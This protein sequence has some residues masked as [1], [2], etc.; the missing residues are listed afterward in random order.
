MSVHSPAAV[1][2]IGLNAR[3]PHAIDASEFFENLL[4]GRDCIAPMPEDRMRDCF[5]DRARIDAAHAQRLSAGYI[6]FA[7]RF[8]NE[9]F[10]FLP[11][12]AA[13]M[14]PQQ[15]LFMQTAWAALEDAGYGPQSLKGRR[16]GVFVG[17]GNADYPVMMR[18]DGVPVDAYRA[19]GM[20]ITCIANRVSYAFD[21]RGPSHSI[22]TACSSSLIAI[23]QACR[24]IRDGV[25]K[26][27]IA[28]GVNLLLG[29]ELFDAFTQAGMLSP[30][31]RC[32]VFDAA[33]DGYVRGEGVVAMVLRS[34]QDAELHRDYIYGSVLAGSENHGGRAHSFTA[35]NGHAQADVIESAWRDAG[36]EFSQAAFIE[37]H[38]TGTPLGDPIE[39]NGIKTALR[40][41]KVQP[42]R[43]IALG[44][45][46][47]HIGHL[48]A[49][50][51]AAAVT[52]AL[53][54]MQ[55]GT[56]PANLHYTTLNPHIALENVPLALATS[57]VRFA[58]E[59]E[60]LF[61]GVSSFGFGGVNAHVVLQG[62]ARSPA[63]PQAQASQTDQSE[64][65]FVLS[66]RTRPALEARARQLLN[67]LGD[68]GGGGTLRDRLLAELCEALQI[69]AEQRVNG[70]LRLDMLK[71]APIGLY[72]IA[73]AIAARHE[74]TVDPASLRDLVCLPGIAA[75]LAAADDGR[76]AT[77]CSRHGHLIAGVSQP[78]NERR[79]A[80][81]ADISFTLLTGRDVMKH[82]LALT[83]AGRTELTQKLHR[84]LLRQPL[85]PDDFHEGAPSAACPPPASGEPNEPIALSAFAS[86]F[87]E[88]KT[89]SLDWH[90]LHP[91]CSQPRRIPL[92][93]YPFRLT[94]I[95]Y[96][97][98][99]DQAKSQPASPALP[100]SVPSPIEAWKAAWR[101][102][103]VKLPASVTA[104]L[105][106]LDM[107]RDA[108]DGAVFLEGIALGPPQDLDDRA[109]LDVRRV[110][111]ALECRSQPDGWLL[112]Q[113]RNSGMAAT[114]S[115]P[116]PPARW[117][118]EVLEVDQYRAALA[119]LGIALPAAFSRERRIR[120]A[121]GSLIIDVT[122]ESR[123]TGSITP[124]MQLLVAA[125][126]GLRF[127][128]RKPEAPLLLP[129]RIGRLALD[130]ALLSGTTRLL[131]SW[132]GKDET[133]ADAFGID[134][135][136]RVTLAVTDL[137]FRRAPRDLRRSTA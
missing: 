118:S 15:R 108:G 60:A 92:P 28:G 51:G 69:P 127:L 42:D 120:A 97:P 113:A 22:D 115:T 37:T 32:R 106:M 65:L 23:E 10:N 54:V 64:Y 41:T 111:S 33:A 63:L 83:A 73:H 2:V 114:A 62:A 75:A 31:Q 53:L 35:P 48:E 133:R 91:A 104:L 116:P 34:R 9:L 122:I 93:P 102:S 20:A 131:L 74:I 45:L 36:V 130:G 43:A 13:S 3:L 110:G 87:A 81:L 137:E 47:S 52:K 40:N 103:S 1:A 49:A 86:Y 14:D 29:P 12:E 50:A 99:S 11:R 84:F 129:W 79:T 76:A 101:Y 38:G 6:P 44:A 80:S 58:A 128:Q 71:V 8:D 112:A 117:P 4:A 66:A 96:E 30:T 56:L 109:D 136:R 123:D 18:R 107:V 59:P 19:T 132:S 25:C 100:K 119:K 5:A 82:R 135:R 126:A 89:P 98:A 105:Q 26:M 78:A 61:A 55:R 94:R 121:A 21:F 24:A 134:E 90:S 77:I 68:D 39:I 125:F 7:D 95:W 17:V 70:A 46:K 124:E 16:V 72:A 57:A 85:G 27:A 88:C 67:F